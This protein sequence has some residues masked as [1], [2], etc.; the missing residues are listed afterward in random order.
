MEKITTSERLQQILKERN[1][2]QSDILEACKPICEKHGVKLQKSDLSQY[3]SGKVIPSQDKLTVLGLALNV[4]EVW[5]MGYDVPP[6]RN[7]FEIIKNCK[8]HMINITKFE[9]EIIKSYRL[10]PENIKKGICNMLNVEYQSED[11]FNETVETAVGK[12]FPTGEKIGGNVN[13]KAK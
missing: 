10:Q 3:I 5:L 1:I 2:K 11:T 12:L 13:T 7:A 8:S 4:N 6:D 9:A